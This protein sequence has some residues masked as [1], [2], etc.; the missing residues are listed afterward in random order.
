MNSGSDCGGSVIN[1]EATERPMSFNVVPRY[2]YRVNKPNNNRAY[3][4]SRRAARS[5]ATIDRFACES[6]P[7]TAGSVGHSVA[8]APNIAPALVAPPPYVAPAPFNI[9]RGAR[10]VVL[11]AAQAPFGAAASYLELQER[12]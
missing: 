5:D 12:H 11:L 8:P 1:G 9:R 3:E 4:A 7:R 10:A 6:C 2:N